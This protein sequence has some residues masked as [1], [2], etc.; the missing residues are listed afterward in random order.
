M[1]SDIVGYISA[2]AF[3]IMAFPQII[4]IILKK[5]GSGTSWGFIIL[6]YIGNLCAIYYIS[7]KDLITG[8]THYPLYLNYCVAT[9]NLVILTILKLRYKGENK[10]ER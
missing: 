3:A 6:N 5:D 10:N 9:L 7:S 2:I 4:T 1:L 8:E